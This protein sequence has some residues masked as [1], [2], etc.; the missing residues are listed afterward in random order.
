MIL[1][2]LITIY[3]YMN[4]KLKQKEYFQSYYQKNKD[5]LKKKKKRTV[6]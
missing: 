6:L 1:N 5:K 3:T 2:C 4:D